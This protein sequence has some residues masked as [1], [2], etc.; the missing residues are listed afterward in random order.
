MER[1]PA[2]LRY[3]LLW[4]VAGAVVAIVVVSLL[5]SYAG[6]ERVALPPLEQTRLEPAAAAAG[7]VLQQARGATPLALPVTGRARVP[8][9]AP[10]VYERPPPAD[11]IVA[12][13]RRGVVVVY[14]ATDLRRDQIATLRALRA[15]IPNGTILIAQPEPPFPLAATAWRHLL[16]CADAS[17]GAVEAVRL[18]RARFLGRGAGA[19]AR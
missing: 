10:G 15:A 12:A 1:L 7:C 16:G 17:E 3:T 5:D 9:A 14:H 18:F 13:L 19:A 11:A 4:V 2:L 6:D 8:P